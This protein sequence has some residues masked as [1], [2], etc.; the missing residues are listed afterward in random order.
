MR[1][2]PP[3]DA[4]VVLEVAEVDLAVVLDDLLH[5][6]DLLQPHPLVA[7]RRT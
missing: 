3:N 7:S 4:L 1:S 5:P 6:A 2:S